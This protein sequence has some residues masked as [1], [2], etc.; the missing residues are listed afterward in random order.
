MWKYE[1]HQLVRKEKQVG[2]IFILVIFKVHQ[3]SDLA[4]Y[5][6]SQYILT[7]HNSFTDKCQDAHANK[8][9]R[10]ALDWVPDLKI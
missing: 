8:I 9:S 10:V 6:K 4:T 7:V 3:I 2:G 1:Y 5:Q